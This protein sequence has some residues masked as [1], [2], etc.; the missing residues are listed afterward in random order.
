MFSEFGSVLVLLAFWKLLSGSK[1]VHRT[2]PGPSAVRDGQ[3]PRFMPSQSGRS[4]GARGMLIGAPF[5][6]LRLSSVHWEP[7]LMI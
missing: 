4:P 1:E 3:R 6:D 2:S 7:L 5:W